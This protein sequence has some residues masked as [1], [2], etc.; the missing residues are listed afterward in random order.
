[1]DPVH[2]SGKELLEIAIKI[3]EN[4]WA[5]YN[6]AKKGAE[7]EELRRLFEHLASQELEHI[8][9]FRDLY[10]LLKKEREEGFYGLTIGEEESLYLKAL[11]GSRVFTDPREGLRVA[12]EVKSDTE[13]LEVAIG[14]EKDS[15]LFYY[16]MYNL[17]P[18]KE[19]EVVKRL[20]SQEREHLTRLR[21]IQGSLKGG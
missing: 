20:I 3:E 11:A 21:E 6:E 16:E 7:K 12:R 8:E 2:F 1:M 18:E 15:L 14:F 5:F 19:R 10:K 17:V 13:A 9:A 4:G